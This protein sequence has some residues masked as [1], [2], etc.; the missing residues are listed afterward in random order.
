ML[1]ENWK[2]LPKKE[3]RDAVDALEFGKPGPKPYFTM[4][5]M[6]LIFTRTMALK[7]VLLFRELL[8]MFQW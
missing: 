6:K 1:G 8:F 3:L 4:D 2:E 7:T 5:E